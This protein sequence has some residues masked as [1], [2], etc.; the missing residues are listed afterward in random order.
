M[1]KMVRISNPMTDAHGLKV[2]W[3]VSGMDIEEQV[4]IF[5]C[6]EDKVAKIHIYND[7]LLDVVTLLL[8]RLVEASEE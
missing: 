2:S 5:G 4:S 8:Q 6:D 3:C 1:D 7:E